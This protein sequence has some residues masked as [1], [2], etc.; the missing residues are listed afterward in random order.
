MGFI[1]ELTQEGGSIQINVLESVSFGPV[2][3]GEGT[4]EGRL[5]SSEISATLFDDWGNAYSETFRAQM[6][7]SDDEQRLEGRTTARSTGI[8]TPVLLFRV[9]MGEAGWNQNSP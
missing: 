1:Y 5:L 2:G 9:N 7:L 4:I 3:Y 8:V 6:T